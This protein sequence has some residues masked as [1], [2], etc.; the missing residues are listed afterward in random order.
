M[1][2]AERFAV[3]SG[4]ASFAVGLW[5][6]FTQIGDGAALVALVLGALGGGLLS[7]GV[8]LWAERSA[9]ERVETQGWC[10]VCGSLDCPGERPCP[11]CGHDHL[12][13]RICPI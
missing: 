8:S 4:A 5:L 9:R 11:R 10:E 6:A 13:S 12:V 3:A 1:M 2:E 7:I